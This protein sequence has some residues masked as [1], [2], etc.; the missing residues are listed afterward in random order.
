MVWTFKVKLTEDS[1]KIPLKAG[2]QYFQ[3][4]IYIPFGRFYLDDHFVR[5]FF[6]IH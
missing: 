5:W 6:F 3:C 4:M 2:G 1:K